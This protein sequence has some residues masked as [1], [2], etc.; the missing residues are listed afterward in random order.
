V[1]ECTC[2]VFES[3]PDGFLDC[4]ARRLSEVLPGPCIIDLPGRERRPL[5]VSVLLH[6]NEDT[7]LAAAQ[8][9][10][11]GHL[12]RQLHRPLLLFVGNVAAATENVR[13]LPGQPDYNRIWPGTPTPDVPEA[14]MARWV[15]DYAAARRPF[16]S[17]DIHNN[18]GLN[19]HYACI[20][21]LEPES[22]ALARLFS[23]TIVH[24][25]RPLGVQTGAFARVC[26]SIAVECGMPGT[27]TEHAVELIE[28][29]LSI[30]QLPPHDIAPGEVD[31]FRTYAIVKVPVDATFSFD[32]SPANLRFRPDIDRMNFSELS[33]GLS[34][35]EVG[36]GKKRLLVLPAEESS[37]HDVYFDYQNGEIRLTQD[38]VP[39]MLTQDPRAIRQDCFCYFMHRIDMNGMRV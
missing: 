28:S 39:A 15:F 37:L 10:L 11:R 5:F 13:T 34:L 35:G 36:D 23:R 27:G 20:T 29:C 24:F 2:A 31:L 33:A 1:S 30:A 18:T 12:A 22:V 8:E 19:P 21:R 14:N 26:P 38:V 25:E 32:G 4:P 7:G 16:A 9:V 6:G 17:V 3:I